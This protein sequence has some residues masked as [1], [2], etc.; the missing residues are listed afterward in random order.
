MTLSGYLKDKILILVLNGVSLFL[1]SLYLLTMGNTLLTVGLV[2]FFWL[3]I[4]LFWLT[5]N[6]QQRKKYFTEIMDTLDSLE[7]PYL[8]QEFMGQSWRLEDQLYQQILRQSNKSVIEKIQALE[9]EQQEYREYIEGWVH[10]VKLPITGMRLSAHNQSNEIQRKFEIYLT[11]M[12]DLVE[13]A[14]FYARSDQVY[15]DYALKET[16]LRQVVLQVL[17]KSKYLLIHHQM[18]AQ[19]LTQS[20]FVQTDEK[21]VAFILGQ[22]LINAMKYKKE[23]PGTLMFALEETDHEI[24][25]SLTDDGIGIPKDELGRLFEKGFTGSNGR[26]REKTTGIGLYLCKKL[27]DKLELRIAIDSVQNEY[28]TVTLVFS[29]N[30]YL[31]KL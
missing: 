15:K 5:V 19:P 12:D 24:K 25:L 9:E 16:D 18:T 21:W 27:C 3:T 22:L 1:L 17:G 10:E 8:I 6:Y 7:K 20:T 23:G 13:Q 28:T 30:T 14:L 31:S 26:K 4:L 2:T 11:E 29:K